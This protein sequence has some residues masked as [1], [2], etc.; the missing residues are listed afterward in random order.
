MLEPAC[1]LDCKQL[2]RD[3]YVNL[4][5]TSIAEFPGISRLG[6]CLWKIHLTVICWFYRVIFSQIFSE[7]LNICRRLRIKGLRGSTSSVP[8]LIS[9]LHL[10]IPDPLSDSDVGASCENLQIL[11]LSIPFGFALN[12]A[13]LPVHFSMFPNQE[14]LGLLLPCAPSTAPCTIVLTR[15]HDRFI[16]QNHLIF[17]R[18]IY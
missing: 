12:L 3:D 4:L 13:V 5:W 6:N 11:S 17:L 15:P 7:S 10:P 18:G 14:V 1:S 8:V 2:S 16:W 9:N